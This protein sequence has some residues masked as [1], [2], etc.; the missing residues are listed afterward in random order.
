MP[1]NRPARRTRHAIRAT[2]RN[3]T[4]DSMAIHSLP[5]VQSEITLRTAYPPALLRSL[6]KRRMPH[7]LILLDRLLRPCRPFASPLSGR[8]TSSRS[9]CPDKDPSSERK[10]RLQ[11]RCPA[12]D[13]NIRN[14]EILVLEH[15]L[16][17][18]L[19][20]DPVLDKIGRAHV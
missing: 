6:G 7:F 12:S 1:G 5:Q 14:T 17:Q 3:M 15:A 18:R 4:V 13:L 8:R 16:R 20:N 19:T 10:L 9:G 11:L 2:L